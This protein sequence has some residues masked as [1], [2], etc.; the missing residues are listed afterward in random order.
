M[1]DSRK[2]IRQG[3]VVVAIV[4]VSVVVSI[5]NI[6]FHFNPYH[7]LTVKYPKFNGNINLRY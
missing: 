6:L 3:V 4:G 2:M 1:V 5:F 7:F